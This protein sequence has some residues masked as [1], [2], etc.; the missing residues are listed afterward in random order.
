MKIPI[1]RGLANKI[2]ND[3]VRNS[4]ESMKGFGWSEKSLQA[5]SPMNEN[6]L[7]GIRTSAKYL[8]YQEKGTK[9]FLMTWVD[10]RTVPIGCKQGDGPHFRRGSHAGEPGYVN[11]PHVGRVWRNQRWHNPG[12]QGRHFMEESLIKAIS[13]NQELIKQWGLSLFGG[14]P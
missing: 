2:S 8:M 13:D 1:S 10:G 4:R 12:I 9:P 5:V 7:V 6:G 3:A 11:I 14:H